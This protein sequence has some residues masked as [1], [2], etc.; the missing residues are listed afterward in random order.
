MA[1]TQNLQLNTYGDSAADGATKFSEWRS[2]VAGTGSDSNMQKIDAAYGTLNAKID[3]QIGNVGTQINNVSKDVGDLKSAFTN[4]A[5]N[6]FILINPFHFSDITEKGVSF[7][8]D[9]D[10][11]L[12]I[13]GT[14]E[15]SGKV[16]VNWDCLLSAGKWHMLVTKISG[17]QK[18]AL[19][20]T[21]SAGNVVMTLRKADM[22]ANFTVA[23]AGRY[24]AYFYVTAGETLDYKM[25][26]MLTQNSSD[27]FHKTEYVSDL[28][29][30]VANL[31]DTVTD[32]QSTITDLAEDVES[33]QN[34]AN[35]A[36]ETIDEITEPTENILAPVSNKED[37]GLTITY[38]DGVYSITGTKAGTS[39]VAVG[40]IVPPESGNYTLSFVDKNGNGKPSAYVCE[41]STVI[42]TWYRVNSTATVALTAETT[43][44]F[45]VY[46]GNGDTVDYE[47]SLMCNAG[48]A[49]ASFVKYGRKLKY[50]HDL[51]A[52][53]LS[54]CGVSIDTYYGWIPEGNT[55]YYT[56]SNLPSVDMTWWK[57]LMDETGISLVINNSWSGACAST[58]NGLASSGVHRC[59]SLHN[60]S[61]VP[62]IIIIGMFGANDWANTTVGEYTFTTALPGSS[63]DLSDEDV[64]NAYK[65]TIEK[66]SGAM[67]TMFKRIHESYPNARVYA[68]DMY[69]YYRGE[70]LDPAGRGATQNVPLFNK[71]LYDVAEWFG[72]TVI[73]GSECGINAINSRDYCVDG[74]T[75]TALHPNAKGH[76][77]IYKK[78][79]AQLI[80]DWCND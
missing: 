15:S 61:I 9:D 75:G 64:Y 58:V 38:T 45:E 23:E 14:V 7:S 6:N 24:G 55:T 65:N 37:S 60:G 11:Y 41:G 2:K 33:A 43:Y 54:I 17:T 42:G 13:S 73:K 57:R 76:E 80:S 48:S 26:L 62:D 20:I 59:L 5:D 27:S 25:G 28:T 32:I 68:L 71:T 3:T 40:Q 46:I 56:S 34:S 79:L 78:V 74:A 67:A 16:T 12:T 4:L 47:M 35:E 10:G 77:L 1:Q 29:E 19:Y 39:R 22:S 21:D 66:Y 30:P 50:N 51:S 69:N 31:T 53:K 70:N 8:F 36:I 18:T 52:H 63:I 49:A 44:T 72:V